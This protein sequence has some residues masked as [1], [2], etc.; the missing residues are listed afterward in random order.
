MIVIIPGW[1]IALITFPGTIVHEIS[2]RFFCDI[3]DI[4]VYEVRYF[5]PFAPTS[6]YVRHDG[7]TKTWQILMVSMA[8]LF[9]NTLLCA[10]LTFPTASYLYLEYCLDIHIPMTPVIAP[11]YGILQ[12]IGTSI[13]A[14]A[15]PSNQ[16]MKS[17]LMLAKKNKGKSRLP[18]KAL[19]QIVI[20]LN[21][22]SKIWLSFIYAIAISFILPIIIFH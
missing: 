5:I 22:F 10:L 17:V 15:F 16:D 21:F 2:H 20:V 12:W 8:P 3:F 14:Q 1:I 13:G 7:S 6:G 18:I 19:S 4:P 11:L 9:V